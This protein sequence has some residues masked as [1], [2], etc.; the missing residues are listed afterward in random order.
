MVSGNGGQ[1]LDVRDDVD[2]LW[3]VKHGARLRAIAGW[4]LDALRRLAGV[5][6]W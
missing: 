2:I 6:R 3:Y 5:V 1:I 4:R